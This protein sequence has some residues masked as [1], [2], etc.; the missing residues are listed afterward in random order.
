MQEEKIVDIKGTL[1]K[2][3]K[4]EEVEMSQEEEIKN[5]QLS[6]LKKEIK[7]IRNKSGS[8][9][10]SSEDDSM[11]DEEDLNR[12]KKELL[13]SLERVSKLEKQVYSEPEYEKNKMKI[14]K[15]EGGGANQ[16]ISKEGISVKSINNEKERE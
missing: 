15:V 4:P 5:I 2:F 1:E 11:L 3:V 10:D 7:K 8:T 13:A 14:D 6:D 9:S 12:I 16:S